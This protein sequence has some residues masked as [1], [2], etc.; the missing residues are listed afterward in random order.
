MPRPL[1]IRTDEFPYHITG[2]TNNKEWFPIPMDVCWDIFLKNL[3]E[4]SKKYSLKIVSFILMS[5]HF[6]MIANTPL[7]NIDSIMNYLLREISKNIGF[8][9][10][11]INH[12]FGNKYKWSLIQNDIYFYHAYKY[13]NRNPVNA[14]MVE[15]VEDYEYSTLNYLVKNKNLPFVCSE[16]SDFGN[17]IIPMDIETRLKWLN[18]PYHPKQNQIIRNGLQRSIFQF[19][20]N[21]TDVKWVKSLLL[22]R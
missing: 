3:K 18:E 11:R 9:S 21:K 4:V 16:G 19:T 22:K 17:E 15:R 1:L 8:E 12:I 2:R 6:H 13:L 14:V 5:N 20:K 10:K 7:S